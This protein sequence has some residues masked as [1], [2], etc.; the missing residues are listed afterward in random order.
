VTAGLNGAVLGLESS[1]IREF[2]RLARETPGCVS[3]TLG[4][5]DF[6]T[7]EPV[8]REA[9]ASLA[10]GETHYIENAGAAALREEICRYERERNGLRYDPD[11]VIVTAGA[12]EALFV[13][14]FGILNPGDEVIVP[15]PAFVL[16]EQQLRL[17][18]AVCVKLDTAPDGF[19]ITQ[20]ALSRALSPRTKAIVLNSPNN[21]TG[22]ILNGAS[23]A[24]VRRAAEER[25]LYVVC[26]DVYRR[27]VYTGDYHSFAE[28]AE[29]KAQIL[30]AQSFSK[31]W[32]MTGWRMGYLLA[33]RPVLERL[34]LV[35]QFL[36]VSTPAP[37]QSAC[38]QALRCDPAPLVE[39]YRRRRSYVLERLSRMGL[40]TPEPQG[41]FYVFPSIGR[42]GLPSGEFCRRMI[43]EAGLAA[44]PGA[45]FG[46]EGHIRLSYCYSED[47]LR[48]GLSRL[49]RF[50]ETF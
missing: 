30:V 13:A 3:L 39:T 29:L 16:Y 36:T 45:C 10:R 2:S 44:T 40:E 14:L 18:R 5:P 27:L 19:Q 50:T 6:D 17:C 15:T 41:A 25:G 8:S 33:A 37:F 31:P 47:A 48:E 32:A 34:A 11:E 49:E 42:F 24:A 23:L 26:D 38:V 20:E 43:K 12:T 46:G 22:C 21:P 7:P 28:F 4:E 9:A 1:A 35:H